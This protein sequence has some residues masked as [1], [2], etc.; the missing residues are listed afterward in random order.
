MQMTYVVPKIAFP[1]RLTAFGGFAALGLAAQ[2]LLPGGG[3]FILGLLLMVPG[4]VLISA[5]NYR[6]KPMDIGLEDWQPASAAEFNRVRAN[7]SLTRQSRFSI[8]YKGGLGVAAIIVL[9]VISFFLF[10]SERRFA[11]TLCIDAL[12]LLI[13]LLFTGNVSLWTPKEL[14]RKMSAFEAIVT[15]EPTEGGPIIITPYLRLDKDKEGRQI[16]EDIRLMVEPRR[17]PADFL[18]VQLQV[19]INNGE[20]GPVPYMYAVFL[21]RGK[22]G[23][24]QAFAA[25]RFGDY[26]REPGGDKE[27]GFVVVRQRTERGGFH[28]TPVDC[29]ELY[30]MVKEKLLALNA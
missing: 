16:P 1:A 4:L 22:G 5:K 24:Y 28:T 26:V 11:A 10:G 27:Y 8:F 30:A 18:G 14:A 17:K 9:G 2:I 25:A 21:C 6:N 23:T 29:R 19:A 3:G 13:P 20:H 15:S 12:V 7:L